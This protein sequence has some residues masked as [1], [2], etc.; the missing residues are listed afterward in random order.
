MVS[1]SLAKQT[2]EFFEDLT[3]DEAKKAALRTTGVRARARK[4]LD[5]DKFKKLNNLPSPSNPNESAAFER[6]YLSVGNDAKELEEANTRYRDE[7]KAQLQNFLISSSPE[8]RDLSVE[9]KNLLATQRSGEEK[10][11]VRATAFKTFVDLGIEPRKAETLAATVDW[12]PILGDVS[13][14]ED[15]IVSYK[16]G[17]MGW[18]AFETTLGIIGLAP[19]VGDVIRKGFKTIGGKPNLDFEAVTPEGVSVP[20]TKEDLIGTKNEMFAGES[21]ELAKSRKG[22]FNV[23]KDKL[24]LTSLEDVGVDVSAIKPRVLE[25]L[26]S[27]KQMWKDFKIQLKK[28]DNIDL[29]TFKGAGSGS[30]GNIIADIKS[31]DDLTKAKVKAKLNEMWV[32][33]GWT[34]GSKNK[35]F[36][37]IDDSNII[38]NADESFDFNKFSKNQSESVGFYKSPEIKLEEVLDH[39]ELYEAYPE[40]KGLTV[41]FD[42]GV[43]KSYSAYY[44]SNTP[45]NAPPFKQSE[46]V[47]SKHYNKIENLTNKNLTDIESGR[48]DFVS[49]LLHEIQHAI[50]HIEFQSAGATWSW[51]K[52][53]SKRLLNS[54]DTAIED[55]DEMLLD[56]LSPKRKESLIA[57]KLDLQFKSDKIKSMDL[58]NNP[59]SGI[60]SY[61]KTQKEVEA[62]NV[63]ERAFYDMNERYNKSPYD[64]LT[65]YA[66]GINGEE[67]IRR[68]ATDNYGVLDKQKYRNLIDKFRE[69][70][71]FGDKLNKKA[72]YN[73]LYKKRPYAEYQVNSPAYPQIKIHGQGVEGLAKQ[74][75]DYTVYSPLYIGQKFEVNEARKIL[76]SGHNFISDLL[77]QET[78]KLTTIPKTIKTIRGAEINIKN[79]KTDDAYYNTILN[80]ID[81]KANTQKFPMEIEEAVDYDITGLKGNKNEFEIPEVTGRTVGQQKNFTVAPSASKSGLMSRTDSE[82]RTL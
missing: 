59:K 20:I 1:I 8:L 41:R 67:I 74:F 43:E 17:N 49:T 75:H 5:E 16:N 57:K 55:I 27:S 54:I 58:K 44:S 6:R 11:R 4:K 42:D 82:P 66:K 64:T 30:S 21:S 78:A 22:P 51:Q 29:N 7:S 45:R 18:A 81:A 14:F 25:G 77:R 69:I 40:L 56:P 52:D 36:T 13:G 28:E 23:E 63:Q 10:N 24:N 80:N 31:M 9:Q 46:I 33:T 19:I 12:T 62:R 53:N 35:F 70:N 65:T 79:I 15:A 68:A 50:Q 73:L 26:D 38:R 34:V 37:E 32:K 61:Y 2:E 60:D 3:S 72:V 76:E 71:N 48:R 47:M 39:P